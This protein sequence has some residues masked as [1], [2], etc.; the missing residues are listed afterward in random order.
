[1]SLPIP[2]TASS[3][4]K[5][6]NYTG[7]LSISI[8]ARNHSWSYPLH[9]RR[10]L[11]LALLL[12]A[13]GAFA[14]APATTPVPTVTPV[15]VPAPIS[16]AKRAKSDRLLALLKIDTGLQTM[17]KGTQTRIHG[18]AQ[19]QAA[20]ASKAADQQKLATDYTAK[21]DSMTATALD[22]TMLRQPLSDIYASSFSDAELDSILAFYATPA[23]QAF[24]EKTSPIGNSTNDLLKATLTDLQQKL[25]DATKDFQSALKASTPPTL[26]TPDGMKSIPP[27]AAKTPAPKN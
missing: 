2:S 1:M 26:T 18:L 12:S 15:P 25:G 17:L 13:T 3:E 23:G 5:E 9:M 21:V 14:Q 19:Q 24:V 7:K 20:Q 16:A 27:P 11:S 6:K 10:I 8:S 4:S 22:Y